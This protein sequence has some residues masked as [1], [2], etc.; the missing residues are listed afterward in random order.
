MNKKHFLF[1]AF[2]ATLSV[3]PSFAQSWN[4]LEGIGYSVETGGTFSGGDVA[5]FWLTSGKYGL[6]SVKDNSGYLRARVFRSHRQDEERNWRLG[7]DIDLV[8]PVEHTSPF[9]IQQ[10]NADLYY[11]DL[12][13]SVG[14]KQRSMELKNDR[15]SSGGMTYS[16]N[17][18]PVP[19]V[20]LSLPEFWKIPGTKEWLAIKGHVAYGMFTDGRWQED[21]CAPDRQYAKKVL[22]HS[23]AGFLRMGNEKKFPLT[24]TGG[25]EMY[26]QFGGE[27]WNIENRADAT[28]PQNHI[29]LGHG[30]SD[31]YHV[32]IPGGSDATDGDFDGKSGNQLGSWHF[33]FKW[34]GKDWSAK[35]YAEHYFE[36]H[37]QMFFE[38]GW[39]DMLWG[40]EIN[41]PRKFFISTLLYEHLRTSDQTGGIYH[42]ATGNYN[43][44][45]SGKDNY[46]NHGIY[47]SWQHWGQAM[48]NPLLLSPIY[49]E[50]GSMKFRHNRVTAHHFGLSGSALCRL[51]MRH[52]C[53][54]YNMRFSHVRSLGTYDSPL[55]N[56]RYGNYFGLEV[57]CRPVQ[58]MGWQ[59]GVSVGTNGGNLLGHNAGAS[60]TIRRVGVFGI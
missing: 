18:R 1:S 38:Y 54:D 7:Y 28:N 20:R 15:L 53:F 31:F 37:S 56:P 25:L 14:A 43:T 59:F 8:A 55:V 17:A 49:N 10:L 35:A 33:Q 9:F 16:G 13:L 60:I 40:A 4:P 30:L 24:F 48:G 6:Y 44:Q 34:K 12:C 50:D 32:F 3:L 41:L 36:D 45:I 2:A 39:K 29:K 19:Q 27:A 26:A 47:P 5:P 23:K 46:Y 52:Y 21:R 57:F 42:D 22:Y 58:Y 11:R 51:G